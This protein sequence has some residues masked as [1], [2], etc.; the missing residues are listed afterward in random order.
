MFYIGE[1]ESQNKFME[2]L[3][4]SKD[5]LIAED[6]SLFNEIESGMELMDE[7][8]EEDECNLIAFEICKNQAGYEPEPWENQNNG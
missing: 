6:E 4:M 5:E 7:E 2:A 3:G 8:A 1:K